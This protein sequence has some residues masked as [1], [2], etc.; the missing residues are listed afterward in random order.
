MWEKECIEDSYHSSCICSVCSVRACSR[1]HKYLHFVR[2]S[3]RTGWGKVIIIVRE[4]VMLAQM[5]LA[6]TTRA[7]HGGDSGIVVHGEVGREQVPELRLATL[8]VLSE[9]ISAAG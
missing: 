8:V 4:I 1:G 9:D 7:C 3:G 6:L 5:A 2:C